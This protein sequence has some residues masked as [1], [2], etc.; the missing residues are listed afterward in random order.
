M[1]LNMVAGDKAYY[2]NSFT[3]LKT[4]AT[5]TYALQLKIVFSGG[6]YQRKGQIQFLRIG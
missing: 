3:F 2:N 6:S 1:K 4:T 5:N